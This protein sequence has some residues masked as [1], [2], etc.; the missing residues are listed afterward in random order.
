MSG[1]KIAV[2]TNGWYRV[3]LQALVGA[4]LDPNADKQSLQLY[5]DGVEV[6]MKVNS[7]S[8]EF[9][10]FGLNTPSTSTRQYWL[11]PGTSPGRRINSQTLN[12]GVVNGASTSYQYVV[13][14][15]ERLVY[16]SA[17]LNGDV[18]NFFGRVIASTPVEQSLSVPHPK[19]GAVEPAQLEVALQGLTRSAHAVKVLINGTEAGVVS[20][21]GITHQAK[22]F[23]LAN[24]MLQAG[25]NTISL[26]SLNGSTDVSLMDYARL[27]Y[28]RTYQAD[29]D[30]LQFTVDGG[31]RVS[32]FSVP[33]V[34]LLDISN[35]NAVSLYNPVTQPAADGYAFS[36]QTPEPR[37]FL[38]ITEQGVGQVAAITRNQPSNWKVKTQ[39]ADLVVIAH[40]DF[41]NSVEPLAQL[42]RSEGLTVA[43]VDVEDLYDEFSY[44]A[45]SPQAIRDFLQ[46]AHANWVRAPRFVLLVGD[47]SYDPRN[48]LSN[49]ETDLVPA[50]L[51]DTAALETVS[52]DWFVDFKNDGMVEIAIGRLP[53][54]T[55]AEAETMISK[56]VNYSPSNAV[57]SAVMV[58]DKM[59]AKTNF[60]FEAASEELAGMLP[61]TIGVQK[62]FRGDN[63]NQV[64]HD[65]IMNG[66]NQGPLL[67][68]FLGHGSIEVWTGGPILSTTDAAQLNNGPRLPV[69]LM[70]T[71]LNGYYQ[72]PARESLAES[73]LRT[74]S[75]GAVAV[76]ASSGSTEPQ[77][78][79]EASR[80]LY[81]QLFGGNPVTLGE[82]MRKAKLANE[83]MDVRRTWILL[84]DPSMRIR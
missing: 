74:A 59:D 63:A 53:A 20:F 82:A 47:G 1:P 31:A 70:M 43:V 37:T 45:H 77:P 15:K 25:Y 16:F 49:G 21:T 14:R 9:Y 72:N 4:G 28:A 29:G 66:I 67:V 75:G 6:P 26:Q 17:L 7:D 79:M 52:D 35:P 34:K 48:Y 42:R 81:Q 69:F 54:R 13:E 3:S 50:R 12:T 61:A 8:I 58:A 24:G 71:C 44:G 56:I 68:S 10:G 60:N 57:Q 32:G 36:V 41:R 40:G 33:G 84:G 51:I 19:G 23:P 73:L 76:W 65:Q 38:A 64:V 5:T 55:A 18:E 2:R 22:Q 83:D 27:T 78:Q 80:L 62:I 11:I 39:G 46:F 30:Y